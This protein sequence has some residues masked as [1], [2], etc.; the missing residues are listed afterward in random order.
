[1]PHVNFILPVGLLSPLCGYLENLKVLPAQPALAR[2]AK[3]DRPIKKPERMRK[4]FPEHQQRGTQHSVARHQKPRMN[5]GESFMPQQATYRPSQTGC[6][7]I[8][9]VNIPNATHCKPPSSLLAASIDPI[10]SLISALT[11]RYVTVCEDTTHLMA[12]VRV[13]SPRNPFGDEKTTQRQ[14]I[15]KAC[16]MCTRG[17]LSWE[18][19]PMAI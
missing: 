3:D 9:R 17:Y 16:W 18:F 4:G 1:M 19:R 14:S 6:P 13:Q 11:S 7:K 2:L 8:Q 15:V 5:H 10:G 12:V